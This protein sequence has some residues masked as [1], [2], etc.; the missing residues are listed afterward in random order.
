MPDSIALFTASTLARL[1]RAQDI[2]YPE[3]LPS[4]AALVHAVSFLTPAGVETYTRSD[5]GGIAV[6]EEIAPPHPESGVTDDLVDA[7]N[8][9]AGEPT[10]PTLDEQYEALVAIAD[11]RS[12]DTAP[13]TRKPGFKR[14]FDHEL[15]K[16]LR[17]EGVPVSALALHFGV[18][19]KAIY[20]ATAGTKPDRR[21]VKSS[22]SRLQALRLFNEGAIVTDIAREVGGSVEAV[23][24]FLDRVVASASVSEAA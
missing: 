21:H 8:I 9:Y 5:I 18:Q 1:Q 13:A 16:V 22:F 23:A 24:R 12:A 19:D 3:T 20:H 4:M 17:R 11:E 2:L 6:S 7:V 15:A 10:P 14:T